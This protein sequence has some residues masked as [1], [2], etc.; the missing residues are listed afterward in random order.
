MLF[1]QV[2]EQPYLVNNTSEDSR[3]GLTKV[4]IDQFIV[5][6][7]RRFGIW[8]VPALKLE[9]YGRHV[10]M[11]GEV[12]RIDNIAYKYYNTCQYWWAIA[13][14]NKIKNPLDDLVP[15]TTLIIPTRDDIMEALAARKE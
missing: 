6:G 8:Q 14:A 1:K 2:I 10:V 12:G 4:T 15:G 3:Y 11:P 13:A 9:T 5:P 7:R